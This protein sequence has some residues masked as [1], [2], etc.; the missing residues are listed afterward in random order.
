MSLRRRGGKIM[1]K[2]YDD[3]AF[4]NFKDEIARV[5]NANGLWSC[6]YCYWIDTDDRICKICHIISE[7]LK[8]EFANKG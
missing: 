5:F 2:V 3:N 7:A 8:E 4:Q 1:I 6:E